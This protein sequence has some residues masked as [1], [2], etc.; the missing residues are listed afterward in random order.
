VGSS[1]RTTASRRT[2]S[3]ASMRSSLVPKPSVDR[4]PR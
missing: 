3:A 4:R 1:V 2:P